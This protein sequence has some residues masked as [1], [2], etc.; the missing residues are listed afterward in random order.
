MRQPHTFCL[1][2]IRFPGRSRQA[3]W[4]ELQERLDT[5]LAPAGAA[6]WGAFSRL[7]STD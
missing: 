6:I 3:A 7:F 4:P 1:T 5:A 2:R